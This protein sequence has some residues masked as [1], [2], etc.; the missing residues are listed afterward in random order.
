MTVTTKNNVIFASFRHYFLRILLLA[1]YNTANILHLFNKQ[2]FPSKKIP[3]FEKIFWKFLERFR[4][5][6]RL[7]SIFSV[8]CHKFPIQSSQK[9]KKEKKDGKIATIFRASSDVSCHRLSSKRYFVNWTTYLKNF[10]FLLV[11]FY[12]CFHCEVKCS[13]TSCFATLWFEHRQ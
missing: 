8:H 12:C 9:K 1:T 5:N 3:Y 2:F 4:K 11:F 6:I 7:C 13:N 10:K